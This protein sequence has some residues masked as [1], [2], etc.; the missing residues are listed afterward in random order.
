MIAHP[1]IKKVLLLIKEAHILEDGLSSRDVQSLQQA[2]SKYRDG[3]SNIM[4]LVEQLERW[5]SCKSSDAHNSMKGLIKKIEHYE[6][7]AEELNAQASGSAS[8]L[9][10]GALVLE[11]SPGAR[12]SK[13]RPLPPTGG[14]ECDDGTS[15]V[16]PRL[17]FAA[18]CHKAISY[19][20]SHVKQLDR[21]GSYESI[22]K[23]C[24]RQE[25]FDSNDQVKTFK[26]IADDAPQCKSLLTQE[27]TGDEPPQSTGVP[28]ASLK[29]FVQRIKHWQR[30]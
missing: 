30:R 28:I 1:Q 11:E 19:T 15:S 12:N 9:L 26:S 13:P 23:Q 8:P 5:G 3:V 14:K 17:E 10:K 25:R 21:Q 7:K 27:S 22:P 29:A 16:V 6:T 4:S 20:K 24:K 18:K 2:A